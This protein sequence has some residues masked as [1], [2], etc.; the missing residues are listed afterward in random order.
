MASVGRAYPV[1]DGIGDLN[2]TADPQPGLRYAVAGL[3]D[4]HNVRDATGAP[5]VDA[6]GKIC[7]SSDRASVPEVAGD[8]GVYLDIANFAQSLKVVRGLI[9]DLAA[10]RKLEQKIRRG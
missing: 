10:R 6:T 2:S 4:V 9:S 5:L 3:L 7:V 8:F 1:P